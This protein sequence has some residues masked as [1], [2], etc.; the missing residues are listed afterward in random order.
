MKKLTQQI[1]LKA[2]EVLKTI[3]IDTQSPIPPENVMEVLHTQ[4][5]ILFSNPCLMMSDELVVLIDSLVTSL[6]ETNIDII[7]SQKIFYPRC[8]LVT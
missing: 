8:S 2:A 1:L 3:I 4:Y 6:A 7:S 5:D